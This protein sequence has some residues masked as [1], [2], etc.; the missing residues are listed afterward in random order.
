MQH[1][2]APTCLL[3]FTYSLYTATYFAVET[4]NVDAAAWAVNFRWAVQAAS[5]RFLDEG[6]DEARLA[7]FSNPL[8]D[9]RRETHAN[10]LFV[11]DPLVRLVFPVNPFRL[12]ERLRTQKG[13]FLMPGDVRATFQDNLEAMPGHE[14]NKTHFPRKSQVNYRKPPPQKKLR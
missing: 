3:D 4:T 9:E 14:S 6:K 8:F 1:H 12:N 2:G 7:E 5:Q 10:Y 11:E 13:I